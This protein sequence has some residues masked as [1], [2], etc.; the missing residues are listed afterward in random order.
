M[1][2]SIKATPTEI[3]EIEQ[4][5]KKLKQKYQNEADFK[6]NVMEDRLNKL[7]IELPEESI[8]QVKTKDMK[9]KVI[10]RSYRE[11]YIVIAIAIIILIIVVFILWQPTLT[12]TWISQ[13]SD[14]KIEMFHNRFT[15]NVTSNIP[16]ILIKWDKG[17]KILTDKGEFMKFS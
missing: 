2:K 9:I 11:I 10:D 5:S 7:G 4:I 13:T 6:K 12:G 1:D 14:M 15:G 16:L 3:A 17:N 8:P